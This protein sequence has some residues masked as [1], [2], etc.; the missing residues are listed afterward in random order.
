VQV[1]RDGRELFVGV[2]LGDE[3]L[4]FDLNSGK[5][6]G[7]VAI[8]QPDDITWS[9]DGRLLVASNVAGMSGMSSCMR[10]QG[11]CPAAFEI[12]RSIH[13]RCARPY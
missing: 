4:R 6:L 7:R 10:S 3:L 1:S 2:Y 11:A 12:V 13:A 8:K 5:L 9:S